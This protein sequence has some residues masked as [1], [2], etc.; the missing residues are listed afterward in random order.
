M[1]TVVIVDKKGELSE[2]RADTVNDLYKK[3]GLKTDTDF[4][5]IHKW[6]ISDDEDTTIIGLYGKRSG[7]PNTENKYEFPP[8]QDELLLFGKCILVK[9]SK[10][11]LLNL[12]VAEWED[13]YDNLYGGFEDIESEEDEVSEDEELE[14]ADLE[15]IDDGE[16]EDIELEEE[17][18]ELDQE[19]EPKR[20]KKSNLVEVKLSYLGCESE[21]VEEDYLDED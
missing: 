20:G 14:E 4:E 19:P 8:P 17:E 6:V 16:E 21:L 2:T 13:I 5:L 12:T 9:L 7:K 11:G 18:D 10:D 15:F 1:P 3:A